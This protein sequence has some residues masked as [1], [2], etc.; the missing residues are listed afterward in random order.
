MEWKSR[1]AVYYGGAKKALTP[2]SSFQPTFALSA[3][4]LHSIE[5]SHIGVIYSPPQITF[6]MSVTAIGTAVGELTNF[7]LTGERFEIVLEET[8]NGT[9][10]SMKQILLKDCVI[11]SASP[12]SAT[13]SGAPAATF[14]GFALQATTQSDAGEAKIG[15]IA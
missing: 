13:I 3:E 10:W 4:P 14:S 9:D 1:L 8:E 7:A 12:S 6:S 2:I 11:T 5:A 15:A